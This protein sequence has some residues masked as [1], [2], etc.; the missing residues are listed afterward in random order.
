[1]WC[2][3]GFRDLAQ[4]HRVLPDFPVKLCSLFINL[5]LDFAEDK[6]GMKFPEE[7][8]DLF[9]LYIP[10]ELQ[11][12]FPMAYLNPGYRARALEIIGSE[13][14]IDIE[15]IYVGLQILIKDLFEA[16]R[17]TPHVLYNAI[18]TALVIPLCALNHG[19]YKAKRDAQAE[20]RTAP[21]STASNA[22]TDMTSQGSG[23]D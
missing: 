21:S 5:G 3:Q 11:H 15:K 20:P 2:E 9:S 7:I 19:T 17:D 22:D 13:S 10:G 8:Y 16:A 23:T 12:A 1:M 14:I 18:L 4:F 6:D